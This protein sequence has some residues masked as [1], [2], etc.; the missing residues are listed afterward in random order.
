MKVVIIGSAYPLRGGL[1]AYNERIARAF[2]EDGDEVEIITFSLQY[3]NFLFPGKTQYSSDPAPG[4]LSVDVC[5]NSVNPLNWWSVG[6]KIRKMKPDLVICKFWLP[7]IIM[8]GS[9]YILF[10]AKDYISS[11]YKI[12]EGEVQGEPP[13]SIQTLT[14]MQNYLVISSII[15]LVVGFIYYIGEKKIEYG[16]DFTYYTFMIGNPTCKLDTPQ[17]NKSFLDILAIGLKPELYKESN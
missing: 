7:F 14:T 3:P 8:I 17:M 4:D 16:K 9:I 2:Q 12:E 15:T 5:I 13:I 11:V 10:I 6:R 1:A